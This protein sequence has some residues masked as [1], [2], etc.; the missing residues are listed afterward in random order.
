[1]LV[2]GEHAALFREIERAGVEC[3]VADRHAS[4]DHQLTNLGKRPRDGPLGHHTAR[5]RDNRRGDARDERPRRVFVEALDAANLPAR[6]EADALLG[7]G[8]GAIECHEVVRDARLSHVLCHQRR[9]LEAVERHAPRIHE[10]HRI[11][12]FVRR[13]RRRELGGRADHVCGRTDR[14]NPFG[15]AV[16]CAFSRDDERRVVRDARQGR[17]EM[18]HEHARAERREEERRAPAAAVEVRRLRIEKNGPD[19]H[20]AAGDRDHAA[21][22]STPR[23]TLRQRS[24]GF[25]RT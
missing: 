13:E 9:E 4:G 20:C 3:D 12:Q 2:G 10:Q 16:V 19:S 21:L 22:P 1:L 7:A 8:R 11:G 5:R 17:R 6:I 24:R 14:A 25:S 23:R 18:L 15:I